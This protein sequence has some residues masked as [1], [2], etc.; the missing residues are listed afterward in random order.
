MISEIVLAR[1]RFLVVLRGKDK[2]VQGS[3]DIIIIELDLVNRCDQRRQKWLKPKIFARQRD[4]RTSEVPPLTCKTSFTA[5]EDYRTKF[6]ISANTTMT[7]VYVSE[8]PAMTG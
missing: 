5:G 6:A 1:L 8:Y 2:V 3:H 7:A 4:C